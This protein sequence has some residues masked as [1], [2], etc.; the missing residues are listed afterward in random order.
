M[1]RIL[2]SLLLAT[3][4]FTAYAQHFITDTAFRQKVEN[5]FHAKMKL[6]G[7]KFYDTYGLSPEQCAY[8][9]AYKDNDDLGQDRTRTALQA[10]C[11]AHA[12]EQR[13][14]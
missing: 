13:T 8:S 9:P 2:L 1:K 12:C 4:S 3:V 5:A 10:L 7:M 14:A 6:I 11:L